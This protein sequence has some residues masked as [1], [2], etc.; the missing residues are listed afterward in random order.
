MIAKRYQLGVALGLMMASV[1]GA[2]CTSLIGLEPDVELEPGQGGSGGSGGMSGVGGSGGM[3]GPTSCNNPADCP[4]SGLDCLLP[5]CNMG[6]CDTTFAPQGNTCTVVPAMG[7]PEP[8]GECAK[9]VCAGSSDACVPSNLPKAETCNGLDD[10]CDGNVDNIQGTEDP[11][12]YGDC[13]VEPLQLGACAKGKSECKNGAIICEQAVSSTPESCNGVDDDCNGAVDDGLCCDNDKKDPGESDVDCGGACG[14]TCDTGKSC[15]QPADC[16]SKVCGNLNQCEPP[17]C[18]D[19]VTNGPESDVDCGG[20]CPPCADTLNCEGN[21]DCASG[22]CTNGKCQA[23]TCVD[24]N[25]NGDES[26]TDCG[27]TCVTKCADGGICGIGADCMSGVC[28]GNICQAPVCN[29]GVK[30][31]LETDIDCGNVCATK[32]ADGQNCL[33]NPDC[34]NDIC[35]GGVCQAPTC[36]DGLKN[37]GESDVDCGGSNCVSCPLGKGCSSDNDCASQVC[38]NNLCS[39]AL[40]GDGKK[41]NTEDCDD[42]NSVPYD[43][44]SE[45][46]VDVGYSCAATSPSVCTAI[47]GDLRVRGTEQCDDGNT[48]DGDG[49]HSD[50]TWEILQEQGDFGG[51]SATAT[52]FLPYRVAAGTLTGSDQDWFLLDVPIATTFRIETFDITGTDCVASANSSLNV[53]QTN[54][55]TS[56]YG[57]TDEGIGPCAALVVTLSNTICGQGPCY[58]NVV[59]PAAATTFGYQLHIIPQIPNVMPQVFPIGSEKEPNNTIATA[60][61]I[62]NPPGSDILVHATLNPLNDIDYYAIHVPQGKSVRAEI[63]DGVQG[64]CVMNGAISY[65]ALWGPTGNYI[66]EDLAGTGRFSCAMI[67]GTGMIPQ[68]SAAHNLDA[69]TYFLSVRMAA[70]N[71]DYRLAVTIR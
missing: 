62:Q 37:N 71:S 8:M 34:A 55:T 21:T 12:S 63:T 43:G 17:S 65:M 66:Y 3:V 64:L 36:V 67:D 33:G 14:S 53:Y 1:G 58:V 13:A 35:I 40:C 51:T 20:S 49:C 6:V 24:G 54:G 7:Q 30:N 56:L 38:T 22:V 5:V 29:D 68:H 70:P 61:P 60:N 59:N 16:Q 32:C 44:C 45:C 28:I 46:T 26:D 50:C 69:G 39:D 23:S 41:A 57:S 47:C 2:A 42:S 18:I 4:P 27:G 15:S 19:G 31:G 52:N 11:L 48:T 10:D 25:K 9:G